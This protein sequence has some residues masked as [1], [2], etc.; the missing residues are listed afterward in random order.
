MK[1]ASE[2]FALFTCGAYTR[3]YK[4]L[5]TGD[6]R[7]GNPQTG[8]D[9]AVSELSRGTREQLFLALRLALI[10]ALE[11]SAESLPVVLDDVL[12]DFDPDR[13]SAVMEGLEK[14][15]SSRQLLLFNCNSQ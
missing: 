13:R 12:V 6:L 7:A 8:T 1:S 4:Q 5:T 15:A 14:F 3:V 2:W 11:N 10:T 9:K